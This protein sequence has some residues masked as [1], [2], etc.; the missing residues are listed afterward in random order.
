MPGPQKAVLSG[1]TVTGK[2]YD[3]SP[4]VASGLL[5]AVV[6]REASSTGR[7]EDVT[8]QVGFKYSV[9]GTKDDGS[10]FSTPES[11]VPS[12]NI[13]TGMPKDAGIYVLTISLDDMCQ[14]YGDTLKCAV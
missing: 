5:K 7:E 12:G 10:A 3:G 9:S 4:A 8:A 13:V 6:P 14:L 1:I 11:V 2:I